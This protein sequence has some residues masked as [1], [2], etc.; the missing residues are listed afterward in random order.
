MKP[1]IY[2]RL[3]E[4]YTDKE[5][6]KRMYRDTYSKMLKGEK[7]LG[8][9]CFA[10]RFDMNKVTYT[11]EEFLEDYPKY[12]S[13]VEVKSI[14]KILKSGKA[15]YTLAKEHNSYCLYRNLT[16]GF[17]YNT[18]LY[19]DK[20]ELVKYFDIDVDTSEFQVEFHRAH[21]ELFGDKK[22]LEV[23]RDKYQISHR[24]LFEEEKNQWHLAFDGL[25][26]KYMKTRRN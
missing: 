18:N 23:F 10:R 6:K 26:Y 15:I 12:R 16:E 19:D 24:V 2:E 13:F 9:E 20:P 5:I 22:K 14:L 1:R 25:L 11:V 8:I 4:H 21:V 17:I 3:L 7:L